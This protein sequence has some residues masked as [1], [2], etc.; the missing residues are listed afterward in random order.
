MSL[1]RCLV[2]LLFL[3]VAASLAAEPTTA[4]SEKPTGAD[5][6][7]QARSFTGF[8]MTDRWDQLF[9]TWGHN[10]VFIDPALMGELK[11]Y[12]GDYVTVQATEIVHGDRG[13]GDNMMIAGFSSIERT[14]MRPDSNLRIALDKSRYVERET[15]S[16]RVDLETAADRETVVSPYSFTLL[17]TARR[18]DSPAKGVAKGISDMAHFLYQSG[19]ASYRLN[20]GFSRCTIARFLGMSSDVLLRHGEGF[21]EPE[22]A[23]YNRYRERIG[24]LTHKVMASPGARLSWTVNLEGV[25]LAR[26]YEVCVL[27]GTTSRHMSNVLEIEVEEAPKGVE[28][29]VLPWGARQE[30]MVGPNVLPPGTPQGTIKVRIEPDVPRRRDEGSLGVWVQTFYDSEIGTTLMLL[31]HTDPARMFKVFDENGWEVAPQVQSEE[32][33]L[34]VVSDSRDSGPLRYFELPP[35]VWGLVPGKTYY[36]EAHLVYEDH[37]APA[38]LPRLPLV[39]NRIRIKF[40]PR[41]AAGR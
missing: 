5:D 22:L 21:R 16:L 6:L 18:A 29:D 35:G 13:F 27:Y 7:A 17:F 2:F 30:T 33:R 20:T 14:E 36:V 8:L 19:F 37:S 34:K 40:N 26:E 24:S 23:D 39:S 41:P 28:P 10:C 32:S 9:V 3:S 15:L 1:R 11:E 25:F 12:L 4:V 31:A 38:G